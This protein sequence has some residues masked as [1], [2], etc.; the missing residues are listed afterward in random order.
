MFTSDNIILGLITYMV[1]GIVGGTA[2]EQIARRKFW[3][4]IGLLGAVI[5]AFGGALLGAW[6][7]YSLLNFKEPALFGVPI[8]PALIGLIIF[9]IP[10]FVL[11]G[12]YAPT[13]YSRNHTWQRKY[14]R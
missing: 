8:I 6:V 4:P 5:V 1:L 14:K 2:T 7:A 10:W 3:P 13:E 12:G 11:R 9:M